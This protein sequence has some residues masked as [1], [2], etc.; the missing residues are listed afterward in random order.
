MEKN[1]SYPSIHATAYLGAATMLTGQVRRGFTQVD[2]AQNNP[3]YRFAMEKLEKGVASSDSFDGL[4]ISEYGLVVME[5]R[6]N[7]IL[8]ILPARLAPRNLP[9]MVGATGITGLIGE[10]QPLPVLG[11]SEAVEMENYKSGAIAVFDKGIFEN[12]SNGVESF[13][14]RIVTDIG[15]RC[16]NAGFIEVITGSPNTHTMS[17]L[18]GDFAGIMTTLSQA[19]NN[20]RITETSQLFLI[21][22]SSAALSMSLKHSDGEIAF[23]NIGL[24]GGEVN[25]AIQ[26]IVS[27]DLPVDSNGH[28]ALLVDADGILMDRG[29]LFLNKGEDATI[30]MSDAP[31]GTNPTISLFHLDYIALKVTRYFSLETIRPCA[32][33]ID[34]VDW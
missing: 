9:V 18:G 6:P 32:V 33:L 28:K 8:D 22:S 4:D 17:S 23:P 30:E 2:V 24:T 13:A 10:K 21:V 19:C 25:Q 15:V 29:R 31:D 14:N 11:S 27:D 34:G 1:S 20:L 7:S 3:R 16:G 26:V 12:S 5:S